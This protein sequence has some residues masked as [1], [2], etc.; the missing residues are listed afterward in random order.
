M[1]NKL[2]LLLKVFILSIVLSFFIKY[3][4]PSLRIPGTDVVALIMVLSPATIMAIALLWRFQRL[5][6][7]V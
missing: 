7:Q 3:A 2:G 6:S 5:K 1:E 4:A